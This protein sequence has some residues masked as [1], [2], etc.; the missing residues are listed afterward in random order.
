MTDVLLFKELLLQVTCVH[1]PAKHAQAGI[2]YKECKPLMQLLML[3]GHMRKKKNTCIL[4][5]R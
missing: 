4:I 2:Q 1:G 3:L 5:H